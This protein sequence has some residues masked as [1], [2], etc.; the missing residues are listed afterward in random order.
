MFSSQ[1]VRRTKNFYIFLP[2]D[3]PEFV[4][5]DQKYLQEAQIIILSQLKLFFYSK[6]ILSR[7]SH[8]DTKNDLQYFSMFT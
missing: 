5:F 7:K 8:F 1:L 3:L 6:Y 4:I 2:F